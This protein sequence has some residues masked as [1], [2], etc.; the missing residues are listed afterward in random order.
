MK[1][2]VIQQVIQGKLGVERSFVLRKIFKTKIEMHSE[3]RL[4]V[5]VQKILFSNIF[6]EKERECSCKRCDGFN[7]DG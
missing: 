2:D 4:R 7:N 1:K 6:S 5:H 3:C